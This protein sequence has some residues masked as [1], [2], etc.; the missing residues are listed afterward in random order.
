[1]NTN[2][3]KRRVVIHGYYGAGNFGDDIILL[4]IIDA[5]RKLLPDLTV[6][7]LTRNIL[8]IP[9]S[10]SFNTV[11]RFDLKQTAAAIQDADLFLC[12]GGGIFQDYSGFDF[13]D[14]FGA[15]N[16]GL[17]YYAVP[18]EM[19]YL[20][21]K[22]IMYYGIG[23]GPIFSESAKR[24]LKNILSWADVITVRDQAS[25]SLLHSINAA[26][27]P[28][29]TADPAISYG[30][31][32]GSFRLN[33]QN[34]AGLSLRSWLFSGSQRS[35]TVK[36]FSSMADYLTQKCGYHVVLFPFS[37]S[38]NDHTLL[39][40]VQQTMKTNHCTLV[41]KKLSL[42]DTLGIL[43]QLKL[44]VGMRLHSIVT[45]SATFIPALG[46]AYDE[47][48]SRFMQQTGNDDCILTFDDISKQNWQE[49]ANAFISKLAE[50]Q[51]RLKKTVPTM[52]L[53]E[54]KNAELAASLIGRNS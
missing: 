11:S 31:I 39:Q 26:T 41:N 32:P 25:A 9:H 28:I 53:K 44:L 10:D 5:L 42:D 19:A 15:K 38:K 52:Q 21:K 17:N 6:T 18:I 14:H 51:N 27:N 4:S 12:G 36:Y 22:T 16:K 43:P 1:M 40:D 3:A 45:S 48:V 2:K 7:V 30:L 50:I 8:P 37:E 13:E 34:H 23:A 29:V 20:L 54:K 24:Y 33:G 46:L 49:K 47:K 35:D